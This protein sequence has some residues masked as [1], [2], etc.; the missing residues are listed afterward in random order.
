[1]NPLHAPLS[2]WIPRWAAR[3]HGGA[4]STLTQSRVEVC[5]PEL[6]PSSLS[7]RGRMQRFGEVLMDDLIDD[8]IDSTPIPNPNPEQ[9]DPR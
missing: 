3:R 5:P 4:P 2:S 7:W 9:G 8:L 6:F 1:M